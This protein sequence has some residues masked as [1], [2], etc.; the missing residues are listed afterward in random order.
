MKSK[1]IHHICVQTSRYQESLEFYIR[2]LG[3][4]MVQETKGFHGREFNTWIELNGFMIELQTAKKEEELKPYTSKQEGIVHFC[5]LVENLEVEYKHLLSMGFNSFKKKNGEDIYMVEGGK[6]LKIIAPEG[7]IVE[8]R[9]T[10][11]L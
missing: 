6:L 3:F 1:T 11:G 4:Q 2:Y 10:A 8:L 9:D 5:L 7:T